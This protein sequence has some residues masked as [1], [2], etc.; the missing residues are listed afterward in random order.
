M[1]RKT[2]ATFGFAQDANPALLDVGF[3]CDPSLTPSSTPLGTLSPRKIC[4]DV[5]LLS[6]SLEVKPGAS[7]PDAKRYILL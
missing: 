7:H 2:L 6:A 3:V 5:Q 4:R 1:F